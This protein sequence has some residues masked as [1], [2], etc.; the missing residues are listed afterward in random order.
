ML[1]RSRAGR[2]PAL[3]SAA[4]VTLIVPAGGLRGHP[5][6]PLDGLGDHW[7]DAEGGLTSLPGLAGLGG[8]RGSC[9][10]L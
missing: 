2:V 1:F 4:T 10:S 5:S 8:S 6:W 3:P 7:N 9:S